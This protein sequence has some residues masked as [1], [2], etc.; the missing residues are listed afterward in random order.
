MQKKV[1][2]TID[3]R[4]IDILEIKIKPFWYFSSYC[5]GMYML[6]RYEFR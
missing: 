3:E 2:K 5:S 4:L 6:Y 1:R